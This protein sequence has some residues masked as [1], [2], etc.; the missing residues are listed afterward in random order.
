LH[1]LLLRVLLEQLGSSDA[2]VRGQ[3][4]QVLTEMFKKSSL[5]TS[6]TNYVELLVLR[7]LQCHKDS[8]KDVSYFIILIV[9]YNAKR[10]III[11]FLNSSTK[12]LK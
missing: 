4:L 8:V 10:C 7:I 11:I 12:I 3:V 6:F 9:Y 1:R 2:N 5:A